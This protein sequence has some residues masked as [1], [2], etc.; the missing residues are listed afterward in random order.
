MSTGGEWFEKWFSSK[1]YLELYSHRDEE[2]A[3]WIINLLQRNISAKTSARVLDIACG[4]G[5]H[6]IELARRG[7][8]VTGFDLSPY[9]IGMAKK[10]L[11]ESKEKGLK[12]KFVIRDMRSFR[13]NEKF[14]IALN[15]FSSFG[16]FDDDRTNFR[17]FENASASLKKN[18]YFVFD[19]LN[20]NYLLKNIVPA[21]IQKTMGY[22]IKQFRKIEGNFVKKE[23]RILSEGKSAGFEERLRLYSP[24]EIKK[25][26]SV[27]GFSIEKTFGDYFG[28]KFS[29]ANSQRF[30]AIAVRR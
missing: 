13:F 12:L 7:F 1:Y 29:S 20:K 21:T 24:S 11:K 6:S 28:N 30:I 10:A 27:F 23:I 8:D 25:A 15:I 3:R 22:T 18:G 5:R 17:V 9:L 16:Y 4:A 14:D 2:D 26:L 19:Y